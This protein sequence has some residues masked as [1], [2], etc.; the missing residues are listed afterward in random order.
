VAKP[1]DA[2][3]S[4]AVCVWWDWKGIVFYELLPGQMIDPNFYDQQ[5]ERLRQVIE[6]KESEL[7]NK[8]GV[9]FHHDNA[10]SHISLATRQKLKEE[11]E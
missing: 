6:R 10:R 8:K 5:V 3:K 4:D 1:S 7:I 9:F 11:L 2:K